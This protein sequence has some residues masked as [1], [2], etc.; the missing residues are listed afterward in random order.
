[1]NEIRIQYHKTPY[2]ELILGSF[3]EELCLCDWRY[4]KMRSAI[5]SRLTKLLDANFIE[6]GSDLLCDT[7]QQLNEYFNFERKVFDIPLQ[8]V[9]TDFQKCVWNELV[10]VPFG[11]TS[12]YLQL[13]E[14]TGKKSAV[15]A[16]AGANGAN[17][18]AIIIPCH[19]IIGSDGQLVGYAGGLRAKEK[20]L[21]LEQNLFSQ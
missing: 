18:I 20:L 8:M 16:V 4:R 17:A 10:K 2:G 5:D 3:N 15:R 6:G 1:M 12:S 11:E 13:A 9:G 21:K 19:R 14:K 7:I